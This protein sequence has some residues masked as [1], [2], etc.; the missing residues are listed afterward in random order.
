MISV[1]G[2]SH[3]LLQLKRHMKIREAGE[4][5]SV[6]WPGSQ[7]QVIQNNSPCFLL[8]F[9]IWEIMAFMSCSAGTL[10]CIPSACCGSPTWA[11]QH[12]SNMHLALQDTLES[13]K[14][15]CGLLPYPGI[16]WWTLLSR[17]QIQFPK[18]S[19]WCNFAAMGNPSLSPTANP[20]GKASWVIS[21]NPV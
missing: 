6:T 1:T 15:E 5:I 18:A 14:N 3:R 19:I 16:K 21:A 12:S 7:W 11:L 9:A 20:K 4:W 8:F 13:L 2:E 10:C 17:G